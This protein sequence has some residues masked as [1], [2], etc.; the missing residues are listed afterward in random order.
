MSKQIIID[1]NQIYD[2]KS[3]YEEINLKFM[4]GEDWQLGESLDAFDDLLYGGFGA[5]KGDEPI[6]LVWKNFENNRE[7]LGF[8]LTL[9]FY[10]NKLKQPQVFNKK[11]IEDKIQK[12]KNT[13]RD[14]YFDIILEIIASH[15]NITLIPK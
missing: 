13:G 5:I 4:Q 2:I 14:T 12:L 15:S 6:N 10:E 3:L 7:V 9:N 11:I 8:D 1:G